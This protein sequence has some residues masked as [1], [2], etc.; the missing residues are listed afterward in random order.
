MDYSST[1]FKRNGPQ[2]LADNITQAMVVVGTVKA[3]TFA[4]HQA[5][6]IATFPLTGGDVAFANAGDDLQ[7]TISGATG[8]DPS[9]TATAGEDTG[10]AYCSATEVILVVDATD[11]IITNEAGDLIDVPAAQTFIRESVTV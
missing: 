6:A 1:N 11:R 4:Q 3:N 7:V 9:G 10:V 8:V 2:Y 5:A